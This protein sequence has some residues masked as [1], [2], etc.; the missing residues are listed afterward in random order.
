MVGLLYAFEMTT[1]TMKQLDTKKLILMS[2]PGAAVWGLIITGAVMEDSVLIGIGVGIFAVA[3]LVM[4]TRKIKQS[5]ADKADR[6]RVW[7]QGRHGTAKIINIGTNGGGINGHPRINFELEVSVDGMAPYQV[8]TSAII[9]ELAIPRVQPDMEI[10][11][12]VDPQDR[13]N[14]LVDAKLTP[15]G[16]E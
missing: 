9:S 10:A 7:E 2:L 1:T 11:V 12:R 16:Y 5:T 8:S 13:N 6:K 3:A 4:V 15:Y 14:L